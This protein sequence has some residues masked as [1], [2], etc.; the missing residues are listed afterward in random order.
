M[1][2]K[3][4]E[5]AASPDEETEEAEELIQEADYR[6]FAE[7]YEKLAEEYEGKFLVIRKKEVLK[8]SDTLGEILEWLRKNKIPPSKVLVETIAPRSFACIL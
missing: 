8:V 1:A 3:R 2:E 4:R 5:T 7:N 6:W